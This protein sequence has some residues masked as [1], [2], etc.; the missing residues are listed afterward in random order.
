MMLR[1]LFTSNSKNKKLIAFLMLL[2]IFMVFVIRFLMHNYFLVDQWNRLLWHNFY[3]SENIDN[4]YLGSSHVYSDINPFVMDELT[5]ENNFNLA[6]A[7]QSHIASYY[8]LKEAINKNDLKHVFLELYYEPSTGMCGDYSSEEAI[9]YMWSTTDWMKPS[10]NKAQ[11]IWDENGTEYLIEAVLPFT[12]YR[13]YL[14]DFIFIRERR[15]E[16]KSEDFSFSVVMDKGEITYQDKGYEYI[17]FEMTNLLCEAERRPE[18]IYLTNDAEAYLRRIIELC[19]E[20]GIELTLFVAPIYEL[21]MLSIDTY[22]NYRER[23]VE[24]AAEY[25]VRFYDFN[26]VKEEYLSVQDPKLFYDADHLNYKG[27]DVFT[28]FLYSVVYDNQYTDNEI[29]YESY[30]QKRNELP[31]RTWGIYTES[32]TGKRLYHI[33]SSPAE[34]L[35]YRIVVTPDGGEQYMI[36]DFSENA[37]F[38]I[39]Q[40]GTGVISV[41]T[42]FLDGSVSKMDVQY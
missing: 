22:D 35:K 42:R 4:L 11:A 8:L 40:E 38:E 17:T 5:E 29:F 19:A 25:G 30:E 27:A 1:N 28:R 13:N 16:R 6:H 10:W 9:Q 33:A 14:H 26:L 20:K 24:I 37:T 41:E 34:G 21:Q 2:I 23:I 3:E 31:E 15:R 39:T 12:R 18:E 32:F 7:L 36:Q